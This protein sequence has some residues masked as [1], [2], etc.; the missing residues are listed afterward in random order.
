MKQLPICL[1]LRDTQAN[2]LGNLV[3]KGTSLNAKIM[4]WTMAAL[5]LIAISA[6]TDNSAQ[7]SAGALQ[8]AAFEATAAAALS[9]S[10]LWNF[11]ATGD[12]QFPAAGLI[13]DGWGNLYGTTYAGGTNCEAEGAGGCGTVFE[14][15]LP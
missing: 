12:G 3:G 8:P 4:I 9:E 5:L 13:A 7:I 15:S 14:L 11:G 10:V 6:T 2:Q 1:G